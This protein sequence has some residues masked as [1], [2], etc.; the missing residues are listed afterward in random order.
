MSRYGRQGTSPS[1]SNLAAIKIAKDLR[2][3][4]VRIEQ[5]GDTV[6]TTQANEFRTTQLKEFIASLLMSR[7]S[8][9]GTSG[10]KAQVVLLTKVSLKLVTRKCKFWALVLLCD[11]FEC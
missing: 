8:S 5:C 2:T 6:S 9:S 4:K 11:V 3:I 10:S 1:S 7:I